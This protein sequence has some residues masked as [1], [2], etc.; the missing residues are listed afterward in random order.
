MPT[1]AITR[2]FAHVAVAPA[3]E[4]GCWE[5]AAS[6]RSG[7]GQFRPD[8][9]R[10]RPA[11]RWL[12]E[13]LVGPVPPLLELDH[14]CRNRRCVNPAHLEPVTHRENARRAPPGG[15]ATRWGDHCPRGH[16]YDD[17]IRDHHGYRSCRTCALAGHRRREQRYRAARRALV[18]GLS[19]H[20]EV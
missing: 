13:L 2:F 19:T 6:R 3:G 16:L 14:L 15:R 9:R 1:P 5:W 4:G 17:A 8:Q 12:F 20:M 10:T 7:Y 18:S 11:H